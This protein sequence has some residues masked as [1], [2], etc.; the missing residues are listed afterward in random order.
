MVYTNLPLT[1]LPFV[2]N[3]KAPEGALRILFLNIMPMKQVTE[4]DFCRSLNFADIDVELL[5]MKIPG[6]S[7]KTTPQSYVDAY[8]TDFECYQ[9]GTYDGFILTGAPLEHMHFHEV[10]YWP[11]LTEIMQWATTHVRSSLYICWGA[12]AA[13]YHHFGIPKY[14]LPQK[15]FG[16]YP[17]RTLT[18]HPLLEG[19]HPEF[20]MPNSRHTEVHREDFPPQCHLLADSQE[21]GVGIMESNGGREV[22][23]VGHLEY[24]PLTLHKEYLRDLEKGATIAP[25]EHYYSSV[26][27]D[28]TAVTYTWEG[29]C[30]QFFRNW[31]VRCKAL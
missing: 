5:P 4:E 16:I 26:T 21:T 7:Y 25:P 2:S 15:C 31:L 30:R 19:L 18:S 20:L 14:D 6:Q 27:P 13:M 22:Y 8:Y 23:V 29:A 11:Q 9:S 3:Q 17:H 12:Q 28:S 1:N 10:R 24:E